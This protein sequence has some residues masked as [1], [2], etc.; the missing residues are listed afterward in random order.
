M[1]PC[2]GMGISIMD[3]S[4]RQREG[5]EMLGLFLVVAYTHVPNLGGCRDSCCVPEHHH[6]VSQAFYFSDSGGFELDISDLDVAGGEVLNID[7]VL[8]DAVDQSTYTVTV[9]CGGGCLPI[10][11]VVTPPLQLQGYDTAV[12]E[13]FTQVRPS[14]PVSTP[15]HTP[16]HC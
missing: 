16:L 7:V 15:G 8:R 4:H 1:H 13:P 12:L 2:D 11:P 5:K 9:G 6:D 10:D 14:T 3:G